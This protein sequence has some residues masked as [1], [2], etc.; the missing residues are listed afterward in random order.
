MISENIIR[1]IILHI[2]WALS[3]SVFLI[4]KI[5]F[6]PVFKSPVPWAPPGK[7]AKESFR[8]IF[9]E[10]DLICYNYKNNTRRR[11]GVK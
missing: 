6:F 10:V 2:Y 4:N 11:G 7:L 5:L 1:K 8:V 9:I 3:M